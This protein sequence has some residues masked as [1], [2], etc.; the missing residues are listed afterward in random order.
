[1]WLL[2]VLSTR[3]ARGMPAAAGKAAI[4][5]LKLKDP[6]ARAPAVA[7]VGRVRGLAGALCRTSPAAQAAGEAWMPLAPAHPVDAA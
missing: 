5:H 4:N 2:R 6:A 7:H 1:M 3:R